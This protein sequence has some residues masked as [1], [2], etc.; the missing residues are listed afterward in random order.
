MFGELH[1]E[2]QAAEILAIN[3]LGFLASDAERLGRFLAISGIGPESLRAGASDPQFLAGV[4]DYLLADESLL[5]MFAESQG[6][7]VDEPQKARRALP[8]AM[9]H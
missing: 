4:V 3:A 2:R 9:E 6:I 7:G 8:G 1:V 5:F